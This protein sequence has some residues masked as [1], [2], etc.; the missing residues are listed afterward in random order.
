MGDRYEIRAKQYCDNLWVE[1]Y[2]VHGLLKA[3]YLYIKCRTIFGY[4]ELIYRR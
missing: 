2:F 4:V 1:Q 3:L